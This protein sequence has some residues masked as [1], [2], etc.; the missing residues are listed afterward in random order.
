MTTPLR[1]VDRITATAGC[2]DLPGFAPFLS[3]VMFSM[4]ENSLPTTTLIA[5]L[6]AILLITF[7]IIGWRSAVVATSPHGTSPLPQ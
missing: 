1:L 3:P 4:N 2:V 7:V 5:S 6:V